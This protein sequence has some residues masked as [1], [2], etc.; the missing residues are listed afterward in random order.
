[1]RGAGH[2]AAPKNAKQ[3]T[4]EVQ[5][6]ELSTI[7][8]RQNAAFR[9]PRLSQAFDLEPVATLIPGKARSNPWAFDYCLATILASRLAAR[10]RRTSMPSSNWKQFVL[11]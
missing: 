10:Q 6:Q 1:M 11:N 5:T 9:V 3:N 8:M 7:A 4:T 2:A